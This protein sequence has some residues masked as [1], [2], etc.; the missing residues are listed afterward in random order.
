VTPSLLGSH[1]GRRTHDHA[2]LR[3]RRNPDGNG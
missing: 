1:I 3:R 2:R